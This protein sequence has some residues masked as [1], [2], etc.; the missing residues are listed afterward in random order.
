VIKD[1]KKR[2]KECLTLSKNLE[3]KP[4]S[5]S[6]S[7]C[8]RRKGTPQ[9]LISAREKRRRKELKKK[10]E[11]G[12][13]AAFENQKKKGGKGTARSHTPK[14]T[15]D[16]ELGLV[17]YTEKGPQPG[18]EEEFRRGK[19]SG[20]SFRTQRKGGGFINFSRSSACESRRR[21]GTIVFHLAKKR[22]GGSFNNQTEKGQE[23][24][25]ALFSR[26]SLLMRKISPLGRKEAHRL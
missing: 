2:E 13:L 22:E 26:E 18:A 5:T 19:E 12:T 10:K 24:F 11:G 23:G 3:K 8:L 20:R 9:S 7:G 4:G 14:R 21:G 17:K 25:H 1:V 15:G 6:S 16:E